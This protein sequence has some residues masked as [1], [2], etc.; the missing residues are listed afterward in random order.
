MQLFPCGLKGHHLE[1]EAGGT[2]PASSTTALRGLWESV[3]AQ[4]QVNMTSDSYCQQMQTYATKSMLC[5]K[6]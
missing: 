6:P 3:G 2:L 5:G 1:G 4:D